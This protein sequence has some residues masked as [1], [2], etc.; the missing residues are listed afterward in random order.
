MFRMFV[1]VAAEV[2]RKVNC[3]YCSFL[4]KQWLSNE[5]HKAFNILFVAWDFFIY[6]ESSYTNNWSKLWEILSSFDQFLF[7]NHLSLP[8]FLLVSSNSHLSSCKLKQPV[9]AC[10]D[11][12]KKRFFLFISLGNI[13]CRLPILNTIYIKRIFN[14]QC[15]KNKF[16]KNKEKNEKSNYLNIRKNDGCQ[17]WLSLNCC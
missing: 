8:F 3:R 13:S 4:D 11:Q 16:N 6:Y 9:K 17:P 2:Q 5:H 15:R 7:S 10:W 12:P 1:T 14:I